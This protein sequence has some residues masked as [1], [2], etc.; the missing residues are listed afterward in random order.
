VRASQEVDPVVN[1]R[2]NILDELSDEELEAYAGE[3][4]PDRET[5]STVTSD[6]SDFAFVSLEP[7]IPAEEPSEPGPDADADETS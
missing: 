6:P 2:E 7:D 4:L 5:L 1:E 3:E